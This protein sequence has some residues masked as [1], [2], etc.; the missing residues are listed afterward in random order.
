MQC[1][2]MVQ[3]RVG[4][5]QRR[6]GAGEP[7]EEKEGGWTGADWVS[8]ARQVPPRIQGGQGCLDTQGWKSL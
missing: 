4:L 8:Q 6:M 3:G 7:R 5:T 1:G 2:W